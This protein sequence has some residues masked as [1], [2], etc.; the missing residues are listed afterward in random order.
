MKSSR[1]SVGFLAFIFLLPLAALAG[2]LTNY[3]HLDAVRRRRKVGT[4][5]WGVTPR[6]GGGANDVTNITYSTSMDGS[7]ESMRGITG[8]STDADDA[9]SVI[10]NDSVRGTKRIP[11]LSAFGRNK[12]KHRKQR[13]KSSRRKRELVKNHTFRLTMKMNEKL[14]EAR[15]MFLDRM[16]AV[17]FNLINY[18]QDATMNSDSFFESDGNDDDITPQSD[19]SLPNR[20]IYVVTTAALPWKTGTAVNPLLRAAY[21][22]RRAKA[23]NEQ[24]AAAVAEVFHNANDN[25]TIVQYN[26]TKQWVTLVIPWL[27]LDEDR[28]ELY[29]SENMFDTMQAQ[30]NYIRDWLRKEANMAEEADPIEGLRILFYP[31]RYHSG[32]NSIFAMGDIICALRNQTDGN[33]SDAVCI[34]EEPEHLNWYR[35]PGE[36]WTKVFNY[37]VGVVHTNYIEYASTQFHGLWTAPAIQVMSSAMIRAYCH[38]V[39]KLSGVLQTYAPEK[40]VVE[41]VHGVREDFIREGRR[42]A[43][44]LSERPSSSPSLNE[45]AEGQIYFIGKILW[46]KGFDNLLE[47]E[48]FYHECTGKYFSI[49]IYGGGPDQEEIKRAFH[50]RRSGNQTKIHDKKSEIEDMQLSWEFFTKKY[51]SLKSS[52]LEFDL[53][54]SFHELRRKPIPANFMGPVDHAHLRNYRVFVNPSVSEVLCTTTFEALAMGKFA[55]IPVHES[56][57]FFFQF[58]NCLGYRNKWEFAASLR[59]ALTH[60][61]EPLTPELAQSFTWEAATDRLIRSSAITR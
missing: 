47:L 57:K 40:E 60:E 8:N 19:L 4:M 5:T 16:A 52:S 43:K 17:S 32:M 3:R 12:S 33:L 42:R 13:G 6:G 10:H 39:I 11:L 37:V 61:P 15:R 36:G 53:P 49:D 30:E 51:E 2:H 38:K 56:N 24:S 1:S 46:A 31:A 59:W 41:N 44:I 18:E 48:D 26:S 29:G 54:K 7:K 58:P 9:I 50:G 45:E 27:E 23:I 25:T 20:S 55:I 34:L 22:S 35:A 21:L 28:I 14:E